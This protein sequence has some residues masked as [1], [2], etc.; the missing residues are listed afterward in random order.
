MTE[1]LGFATCGLCAETGPMP[2]AVRRLLVEWTDDAQAQLGVPRYQ[3]ID[4]CVD[5]AACRARVE[6]VLGVAWPV[7]DRTP[8]PAIEGPAGPG[9]MGVE[10]SDAGAGVGPRG[11]RVATKPSSK[12]AGPSSDEDIEWLR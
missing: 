1:Q 6:R 9:G 7:N 2:T 3:S 10:S 8:A 4:R 12:V 5:R 11:S